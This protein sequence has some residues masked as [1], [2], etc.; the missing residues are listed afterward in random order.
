MKQIKKILIL[1]GL[2]FPFTL[3]AQNFTK[4]FL[5]S[6]NERK[7]TLI[8]FSSSSEFNY[9]PLTVINGKEKGPVFTIVAG[10]HGYEYP[11]I[12]AVQELL[13]E[14]NPA[15]LK[16]TLVVLPIANIASFYKR[17]PFVN[18]VDSKNLNNAFPGSASGTLTEQIAHWITGNIIPQSDVFL[19]IHGGDANEDLLPFICYYDRKDASL[20]TNQAHQLSV[21]SGIDHIVSYPYT[22]S[23]TEPAKYAFKQA[24]QN[25]ITALSIEAGKLGTVQSENVQLIKTAV[26]NM[27]DHMTMY[28]TTGRST[29]TRAPII[30]SDQVYIKVPVKGIFYS[31]FKSGDKV[32]KGQE[33]GYIADEFGKTLHT[34]L[35]PTEGLILYK[36]GTPPVNKDETLFCIGH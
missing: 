7:D 22:I 31:N 13:N 6:Q 35:S 21:A 2:L 33:L 8:R 17:V 5:Q 36:V 29:K 28:T 19:D 27:L 14:I 24:T 10:I 16:G 30:L 1:Y 9:L 4:P 18:P 15:E 11:P 32:L 12:I 25:G 34:I 26:Y 3:Q 23:S 20:Q